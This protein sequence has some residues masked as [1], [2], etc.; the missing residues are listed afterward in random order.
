ML[1][2][3]VIT[4]GHKGVAAEIFNASLTLS[5]IHYDEVD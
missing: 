4:R 5:N 3:E 1:A 2:Q